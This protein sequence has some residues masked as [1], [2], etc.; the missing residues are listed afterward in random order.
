[1]AAM[2][3]A[4]PTTGR[5]LLLAAAVLAL[6]APAWVQAQGNALSQ[7]ELDQINN[8]PI[9]PQAKTQINRPREP[10]FQLDER[11]GTQVR[12][13]RNKGQ[14]TDIQVKSGFGTRYQMS[15]PEDSSPK[16]RDHEVNR[17]PSVNLQF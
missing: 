9:A 7:E 4:R 11:D 6:A 8:Q 2:P 12:E 5:A 15:K 1:M 14:A 17:V 13:Y 16:I 10:S 3:A